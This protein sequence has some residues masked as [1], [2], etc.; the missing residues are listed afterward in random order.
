[1]NRVGEQRGLTIL[2]SRIFALY[3]TAKANEIPLHR[4]QVHPAEQ[5]TPKGKTDQ[6]KDKQR[7]QFV[8]HIFQ[9]RAERED[10][11][12]RHHGMGGRQ[13]IVWTD[14]MPGDAEQLYRRHWIDNAGEEHHCLAHW[15]LP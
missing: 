6:G 13:E 2:Y 1:M 7:S 11:I 10:F 9:S 3:F 15:E 12:E 8:G 14:A 4:T 5:P